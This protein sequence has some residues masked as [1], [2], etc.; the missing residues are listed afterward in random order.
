[1]RLMKNNLYLMYPN[2][3]L[4]SSKANEDSTNGDIADMGRRLANEV[5]Y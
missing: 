1:M 3:L 4:L 2:F 5:I